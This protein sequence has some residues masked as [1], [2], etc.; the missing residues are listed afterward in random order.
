MQEA[1]APYI[2]LDACNQGPNKAERS[3]IDWK[4]MACLRDHEVM[5]TAA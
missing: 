3:A 4:A 2:E 1:K 5:I